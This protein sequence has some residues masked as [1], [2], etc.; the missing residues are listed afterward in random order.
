[1]AGRI[2]TGATTAVIGES[3]DDMLVG[4]LTATEIGWEP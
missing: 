3:L 2:A 1:M 4:P